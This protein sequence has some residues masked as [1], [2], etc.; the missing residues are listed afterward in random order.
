METIKDVFDKIKALKEENKQLKAQAT[1]AYQI[2]YDNLP[3]GSITGG[4][5]MFGYIKSVNKALGLLSNQNPVDYH[6]PADTERIEKQQK[7]NELLLNTNKRLGDRIQ[8][9]CDDKD[10]QAGWLMRYDTVLKDAREALKLLHP[11]MNPDEPCFVYETWKAID[12]L[13][14]GAEG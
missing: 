1:E 12:A 13:L 9:L 6:N 5:R 8:A 7:D 2:L 11:D 14:G 3:V 4:D 10:E